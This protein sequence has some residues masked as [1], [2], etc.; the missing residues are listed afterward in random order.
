[1]TLKSMVRRVTAGA[2]LMLAVMAA[3]ANASPA[4]AAPRVD[5]TTSAPGHPL[6]LA[7]YYIWFDR[8]S[9]NRAKRDYPLAGRYSSD[10]ASIMR[11]QIKEA[12]SAGIDGFIVSWKN[13]PLLN[14]RLRTLISVARIERF[15]LAITYQGLT[16]DRVNLPANRVAAD[17]D[18]FLHDFAGSPVF[19]IFAKPLLMLTGTPGMTT[20]DIETITNGRRHKL[21]I[22]ATEKNV[23][24]YTR[25]A[26]LVD[27]DLYYWSSVN[28]KTY[29]NFA[30]K[31]AAMGEAVRAHNGIW[32]APAAPG[33][34]ARMVG[35]KSV[36]ARADGATLRTEW[37]AAVTSL[38]DAIGIISW[39]EYSEN[40]HIE[41]SRRYGDTYI[42]QLRA[43]TGA[44]SPTVQDVDSSSPSGAVSP[45]R[46]GLIFGGGAA[47]LALCSVVAVRRRRMP[48]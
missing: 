34:D 26:P 17:L 18:V 37:S 2:L 15:K 19:R 43:L 29:R 6:V 36:V 48:S 46:P 9:W 3:P 47:L 28:P 11:L 5:A 10:D 24:G 33:F 31:L 35:G 21:T 25:I 4:A 27:G 22:L 42:D 30:A 7:H 23:A 16:F 45:W 14:S 20:K 1:M 32:I 39:N 12:K 38:P 41:P 8:A 44:N 40:T 13:T